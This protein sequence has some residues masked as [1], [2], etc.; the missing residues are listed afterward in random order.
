MQSSQHDAIHKHAENLLAYTNACC[1]HETRDIRLQ[2]AISF[3]V[4][5]KFVGASRSA[6]SFVFIKF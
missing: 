4:V 6:W 3:P 2:C 5:C 1:C